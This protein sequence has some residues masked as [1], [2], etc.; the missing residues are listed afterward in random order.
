VKSTRSI[1]GER[2][3]YVMPGYSIQLLQIDRK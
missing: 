2:V 1:T 3:Q